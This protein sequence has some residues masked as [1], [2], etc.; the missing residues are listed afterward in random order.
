VDRFAVDDLQIDEDP[1]GFFER[2]KIEGFADPY[3]L[4]QEAEPSYLEQ[5]GLDFEDEE[6]EMY[7][8]GHW[9]RFYLGGSRKK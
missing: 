8:A 5:N 6:L 1:R 4:R 9:R 3:E 2:F 7:Y